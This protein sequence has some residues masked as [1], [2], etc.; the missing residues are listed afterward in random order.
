MGKGSDKAW[1]ETNE[2][3]LIDLKGAKKARYV[4]LYSDG[5]S[6]DETNTYIEVEVFGK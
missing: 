6:T 4:R 2:G 5:S 3:K 1:I